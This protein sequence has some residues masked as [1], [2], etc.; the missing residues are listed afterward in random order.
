V[1]DEEG[2]LAVRSGKRMLH[3]KNE[4]RGERGRSVIVRS[5]LC[6]GWGGSCESTENDHDH[7]TTT[8]VESFTLL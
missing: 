1:A 7:L 6:G 3:R 4:V 5:S 2:V 8:A